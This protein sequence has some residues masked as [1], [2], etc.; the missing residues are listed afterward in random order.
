MVAPMGTNWVVTTV[1]G[2]AGV[3]GSA[4]GTGSNARF[5]YPGGIGINSAGSFCVAD[6]GNNT[7]RAGVSSVNSS[8]S[9]LTQPQNQVLD[10][11]NQT[12]RMVAP[13]GTNWVV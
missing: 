2:Q 10:A 11:G 7:I 8:P 12:V 9:I 4:D 5:F 6:L 3:T 13:M 1:A